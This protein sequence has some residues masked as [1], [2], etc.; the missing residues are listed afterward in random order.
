MDSAPGMAD[1]LSARETAPLKHPPILWAAFLA[2]S[3]TWCIGMFL[4]ALLMRDAG[5]MGYVVFFLPNVIGA[6][7]MGFVLRSPEA[8]ER[9]VRDHGAMAKAFSI[10]TLAFHVYWL[11]WVG[12]F[13]RQ[14]FPIPDT[15]IMGALAI[16]V[17]WAISLGRVL[18]RGAGPR[19][20]VVLWLVG[21]GVLVAVLGSPVS[22]APST[23]DMIDPPT[24]PGSA[25]WLMPVCVFGFMLCPYLDL[26]F[27][28]ARRSTVGV[29][30]GRVAFGFGFW[31][32]F[33]AMI[34]LT[35]VYAGPLLAVL[36]GRAEPT[37]APWAGAAVLLHIFAQWIFTVRVHAERLTT[38]GVGP[39]SEEE[40]GRMLWSDPF[41]VS[42]AL[43]AC[44]GAGLAGMAVP[45]LMPHAGLSAG[46]IGYRLFMAA[47]GLVFPVYVW[48]RMIPRR[49]RSSHAGWIGACVLAAPFFWMGMIERQGIWLAPG[50]IIALA[51]PVLLRE[52][53][54]G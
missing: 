52:R 51:V 20:A 42:T 18:R 16:G 4:P 17:A 23:A 29:R 36:E 40:R 8:A 34:G 22:L 21:L 48:G 11:A 39:A 44:I 50:M 38:P 41:G 27:L 46:E 7:A 19:A 32:F 14:V 28:L 2:C 10:V 15:W 26:T 49:R 12:S 45:N 54:P 43:A 13:V 35:A 3:W 31:V 33:P 30:G 9:I 6:G 5:W 53:E 47:Y 37:V 1:S 24:H 25:M